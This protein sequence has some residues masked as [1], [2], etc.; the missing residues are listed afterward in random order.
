MTVEEAFED[1][2]QDTRRAGIVTRQRMQAFGI[3]EHVGHQ[4][5]AYD[6]GVSHLGWQQAGTQQQDA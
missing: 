1:I 5:V 6:W 3:T 2:A 4:P